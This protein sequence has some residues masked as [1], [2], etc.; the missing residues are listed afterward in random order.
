MVQLQPGCSASQVAGA[1][2]Q[3][4]DALRRI[5]LHSEWDPVSPADKRPFRNSPEDTQ[6]LPVSGKIFKIGEL[7]VQNA[8]SWHAH[9]VCLAICMLSFEAALL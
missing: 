1:L 6:E 7:C 3:M 4:E 8:S 5:A 2:L 9:V